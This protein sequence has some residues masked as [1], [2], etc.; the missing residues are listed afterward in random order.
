MSRGYLLLALLM[1]CAAEKSLGMAEEKQ[2]EKLVMDTGISA[3]D[4]ETIVGSD[5]LKGDSIMRIEID[6]NDPNENGTVT[7]GTDNSVPDVSIEPENPRVD[8]SISDFDSAQSTA[9]SD[10]VAYFEGDQLLIEHR[11]ANASCAEDW[12]GVTAY[13][14]GD[15][16]H[17]DYDLQGLSGCVFEVSYALNLSD[18]A[19]LLVEN[20]LYRV[21][22]GGDI[23]YA[24]YELSATDYQ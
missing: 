17:V 10:F 7:D 24:R 21:A 18:V 20:R 5:S 2:E 23:Q 15:V 8:L 13:F 11:G 14:E 22:A 9:E 19:E 12:G 6:P 3:T 1:G 4:R 16:F